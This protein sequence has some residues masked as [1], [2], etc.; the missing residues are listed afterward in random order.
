MTCNECG[1]EN[2]DDALYCA[3][4]GEKLEAPETAGHEKKCPECGFDNPAGGK[5]CA[6][7]GIELRRRHNRNRRHHHRKQDHQKHQKKKE[8]RVD[9]KLKW[10]PGLVAFVLL[11]GVFIFIGGMEL[12]VK[13]QPAPPPQIVEIRSSDP[14]LEAAAMEIASKFVCSCGTC[15]EQPLNTCTCDRAVEERQF[16]RS[17]LEQGQKPAQ[18]IVALN[19]RYG[20][21]K[22]E[23]AA[24]AG[25]SATARVAAV[26][27]SFT[28]STPESSLPLGTFGTIGGKATLATAADRQEIFSH[29]K[30]PCGQCGIDEL[31]DCGCQHPRGATE[32]KAFVDAKIGEG[33]YT[34]AQLM[35]A[36]DAKYGGRK[37]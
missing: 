23:Y 29:F 24:I 8:R 27:N 25:D 32:V 20:W 26:R 22:P 33:K 7:C 19:N 31:K 21:V 14:K 30:C 16:I 11:V 35:D 6:R 15:G 17:Y 1:T 3:N 13:K 18:V 5:F 36:V 4:C 10:H 12:F 9:T 37:F 28:K 2:K 34:I